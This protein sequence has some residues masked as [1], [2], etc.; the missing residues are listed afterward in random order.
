MEDT[1][2]SL[3]FSRTA[4]PSFVATI[5]ALAEAALVRVSRLGRAIKHHRDMATL[6][7]FDTIGCCPTSGCPGAVFETPY[8]SRYGATRHVFW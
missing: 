1:V 7:G 3:E 6:A 5:F 2:T 8:P 4:A